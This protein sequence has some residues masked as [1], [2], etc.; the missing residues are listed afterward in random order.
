MKVFYQIS[1]IIFIAF[2][3]STITSAQKTEPQEKP[4]KSELINAQYMQ[5]QIT[6]KLKEGVGE[7]EKQEGMVYLGIPS[8]DEKIE[9]F[10]VYQLEKQ[11]R[12]NKRLAKPGL[13]DL[14]RIYKLSYSGEHSLRELI[15][16]FSSD[17]NVEYAEGIPFLSPVAVPNDSL[18]DECQH[19][20]QIMAEEAWD[21]HKGEDG[22]E[23]VVIAIIDEGVEWTHEDLV[24]NTW[25][26]LAEDADGDSVTIEFIDGEWV[27]DPDDINGIDEDGNGFTDDLIGW[28]FIDEDGNPS[29]TNG[30]QHGT[31]CAG[32]ACGT[33]NNDIGISSVSY[34]LKHMGVNM[35]AGGDGGPYAFDAIIYAAESGADIISFSWGGWAY[36]E[37]H[38]EAIEYAYNLGS[39][40]VVAAMNTGMFELMYPASYFHVISVANVYE[41]DEINPSSTYNCAV[42]ISAPGTD[43]LSTV[44][45]N[46]YEAWTGTSM[47]CPMVSASLGLLKSYHPEWTN[48]ELINQII[49]TADEIDDL[50]PGYENLI[51]SGRINAYRMLLGD[52]L[53]DPYLQLGVTNFD[54]IDENENGI[55]EAGESVLINIDLR[56]FMATYGAE[57]A[58]I[59]LTTADPMITI[60][61]GEISLAIPADTGF[62]ILDQFEILVAEDAEVHF[63]EFNLNVEADIDV[64]LCNNESFSLLIE[65]SGYLVYDGIAEGED[66][67]GQYIYDYFIEHDLP[68]LYITGIDFP[69]SLLGFDGVFL[70]FG[71][72][73]SGNT[74][75]DGHSVDVITSYMESG[76]DVYLEGGDALGYD[77]S[78]NSGF[79]ALFGLVA[80]TDGDDNPINELFGEENTLADG[81]IY[82]SNTQSSNSWIDQYFPLD[83][84]EIAF[85]ESGYGDVAVQYD[86][87]DERQSFCF[88][89]AISKLVDDSLNTRDALFSN[90]LNF[91]GHITGVNEIEE[92]DP[93]S[94]VVYPNPASSQA[95]ISYVLPSGAEVRFEILNSLGQTVESFS[96]FQAQGEHLYNW[97]ADK[98]PSGLYYYA[99][100]V[101][102]QRSVGEII[103]SK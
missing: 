37:A 14:S 85:T 36:S 26:N 25:Q 89:Y 55:I 39:I 50:N 43:I 101:D 22:A 80:A 38:Q 73:N 68:A 46:E 93:F 52:S 67:S 69:S 79:L 1:L 20:P 40:I 34:N 5:G 9:R 62:S 48:E 10:N 44:N 35:S 88:S 76:G 32:I 4:T 82:T 17:P 53:E 75:L 95:T 86:A 29:P 97:N 77:Q 3:V 2:F 31:H 56:N 30:D 98:L 21:I 24:E 91:F 41:S 71:N 54:A 90:I 59:T 45:E 92:L 72:Y 102:S 11:F 18:Y 12:F 49:G 15:K 23:E 64:V 16:A 33:T 96:E 99:L 13:P 27:L 74:V 19:L 87:G 83:E 51:G 6:I 81:M 66:Y 28:D 58:T 70:S 61:E 63:A 8:L 57:N 78:D 42:D 7:F 94:C 60:V 84:A 103:L 100:T 47:A 65:P